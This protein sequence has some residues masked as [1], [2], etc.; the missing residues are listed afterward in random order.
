MCLGI[1]THS[2]APSPTWFIL[3]VGSWGK[4]RSCGNKRG[5]N[6]RRARR[7]QS[8]HGNLVWDS[9]TAQNLGISFYQYCYLQLCLQNLS[10]N[11]KLLSQSCSCITGWG[12]TTENTKVQQFYLQ[13]S[14]RLVSLFLFSPGWCRTVSPARPERRN[15][16]G[17]K[18]IQ[19]SPD[20]RL[21]R[22]IWLASVNSTSSSETTAMRDFFI[23]ICGSFTLERLTFS[24]TSGSF[25]RLLRSAV[26]GGLV[27]CP[28][29]W[30]GLQSA[31]A[32]AA[33]Q[34]HI[35]SHWCRGKK[36]WPTVS[37]EEWHHTAVWHCVW[38][39]WKNSCLCLLPLWRCKIAKAW[40]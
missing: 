24:C 12:K 18:K 13:K 15:G 30:K 21:C 6:S 9:D 35:P 39:P 31:S 3:T 11:E 5:N 14:R 16:S 20:P 29:L 22:S 32:A 23:S 25:V 17:G 19:W 1:L 4:D 38:L 27:W 7:C 2:A 34:L 37:Y 40:L 28:L 36:R 8:N 26:D 33:L 10:L